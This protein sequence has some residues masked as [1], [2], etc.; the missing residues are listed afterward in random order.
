MEKIG[1]HGGTG[2]LGKALGR[3]LLKRGFSAGGLS[4]TNRRGPNDD[5]AEWPAVIWAKG[6]ADLAASSDVLV[7]SVRPEDYVQPA[8]AAFAG[9]VISFMAGIPMDRLSQ[10]WPMAR[11][12]RAM[13]GG[14]ATDGRAH[15]PWCGSANLTEHDAAK[16]VEVLS[17]IGTV[18]RV[19]D[20]QALAVLTALSGSGAA[21]PALMAQAMYAH[22]LSCG[23]APDVAWRGVASVVCDAPELFR[24]GPDAVQSVIDTLYGYR[25]ITAAG[26]DAAQAAGLG[27]SVAAAL[28]A[29]TA[30][31][32]SFRV[33]VKA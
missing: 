20:E 17:A 13:P 22:A 27:K 5:Y 28:D 33:E 21:Y 29:A 12:A 26:M 18:D 24:S 19:A 3:N 11:I 7:L 32:I 15:V 25:G 6:L 2:W 30:K 23:I 10:D 9:L 31:A 14:G 16:V 8:P 1:I 4:I